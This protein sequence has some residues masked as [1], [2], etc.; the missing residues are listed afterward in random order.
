M[1]AALVTFFAISLPPNVS[2]SKT[3][4]RDQMPRQHQQAP[5]S[6]LASCIVNHEIFEPLAVNG[7]LTQTTIEKL[8]KITIV[9]K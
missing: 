2:H 1:F 8:N 9:D 5:T 4:W 7:A 3:V 6:T